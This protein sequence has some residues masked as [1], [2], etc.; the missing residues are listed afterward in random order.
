[1]SLVE[2]FC[3]VDD[4]CQAFLPTY[5]Q[6]LV[7][8]GYRQRQRK[9]QLCISEIMTILIA[10]HQSHY[11]DFKTYYV[12]HLCKYHRGDFPGLVKYAHSVEPIPRALIP[13]CA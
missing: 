2:L 3:H 5:H 11:R 13:L 6:A 12:E 10:F 8:A 4:F 1:M 9:G 7:V